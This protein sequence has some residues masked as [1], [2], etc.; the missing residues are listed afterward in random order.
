MKRFVLTNP[1]AME[2]FKRVT[3]ELFARP[4]LFDVSIIEDENVAGVEFPEDRFVEYEATDIPW[5]LACGLARHNPAIPAAYYVDA[6]RIP[7]LSIT[8]GRFAIEFPNER[9]HEWFR[10]DD[11]FCMVAEPW[12]R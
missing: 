6:S 12:R 9:L 3:P 1:P 4:G 7:N 5:A 8:N 2:A 10:P 11:G